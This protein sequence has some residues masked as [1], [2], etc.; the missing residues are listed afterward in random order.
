MDQT[1]AHFLE[2]EK[3]ILSNYQ[4]IVLGYDPDKIE[5]TF[6]YT[7]QITAIIFAIII[8]TDISIKINT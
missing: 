3:K 6:C 4:K 5:F 2:N 8:F 1:L 7:R